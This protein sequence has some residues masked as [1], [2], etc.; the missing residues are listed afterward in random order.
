MVVSVQGVAAVL[1]PMQICAQMDPAGREW[2]HVPCPCR[3]SCS[4]LQHTL[5]VAGTLFSSFCRNFVFFRGN[6]ILRI[7]SD[8]T[9]N[10]KSFL[11]S[12]LADTKLILLVS[13]CC[14]AVVKH[15]QGSESSAAL[16]PAKGRLQVAKGMG[17]ERY[18]SVSIGA[19][20]MQHL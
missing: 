4:C 10:F 20:P 8:N 15:C 2:L 12:R 1:K 18:W 6:M 16:S 11:C 3:G 7:A 14:Q 9:H 19:S 17:W 5:P 13:V